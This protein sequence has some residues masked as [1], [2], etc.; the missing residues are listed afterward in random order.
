M[1]HKPKFHYADFH[2]NFTTGKVTN[3]DHES[4]ELKWW[5]IKKSWSFSES[6]WH[7]S[8]QHVQMFVT[9]S[10]TKKFASL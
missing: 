2:R 7:K 4:R 5:Q 1:L 3:T 8:Y 9:K 10:V 6:R